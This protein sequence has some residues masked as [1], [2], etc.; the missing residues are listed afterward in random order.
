VTKNT[1]PD[2]SRIDY[3][4]QW[5]FFPSSRNSHNEIKYQNRKNSAEPPM[6]AIGTIPA[7]HGASTG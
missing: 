2:P 1:P 3:A 6:N 4:D 7:K 5:H